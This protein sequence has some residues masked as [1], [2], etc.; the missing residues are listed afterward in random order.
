M[1]QRISNKIQ[2]KMWDRML[3]L[4]INNNNNKHNKMIWKKSMNYNGYQI[5]KM[6]LKFWI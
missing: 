3:R 1:K 2:Q 5:K 4:L 6:K